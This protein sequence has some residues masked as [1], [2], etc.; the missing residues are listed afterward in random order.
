MSS[1][2]KEAIQEAFATAESELQI[3]E[4]L[5]I[6]HPTTTIATRKLQICYCID[7][8]GSMGPQ[9]D[10]VKEAASFSATDLAAQ[11]GIIEFALISFKD[12][13]E[14]VL[15]TGANFVDLQ[16]LTNAIDAL[17][18]DGGGDTPE[19]G[20][21][22]VV[23]AA[24]TLPWT[25]E[26]GS[27]RAIFLSTDEPSHERDATKDQAINSLL[28]NQIIFAGDVSNNY[29]DIADQTEGEI[30]TWSTAQE[31]SDALVAL[32]F[33]SI[34]F[35]TQDPIF[36]AN[37]L[38]NITA[39]LETG[40]VKE[41]ESYGF[42]IELPDKTEEG[43]QDLNIAIDN[44]DLLVSDFLQKALKIPNH[45]I[46][47]IYRPYLKTDLTQPQLDP[48]LVLFGSDFQVDNFEVTGNATFADILNKKFL[49]QKFTKK[50]FPG[51]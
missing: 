23:L 13:D 10:A 29:Q 40:E 51:L 30:I 41:F 8:T 18:A 25:F 15:Q 44:T 50:R 27:R 1:T 6:Q 14:T 45:P 36:L 49:S 17:V 7:H 33:N 34:T 11:F 46:K 20:Y 5:E 22:A 31:L 39:T 37:T 24:D 3:V 32:L 42:R 21:G 38:E 9:I 43:I 16:T 26:N 48:P 4:T 2:Y 19:N 35:D 47:F 12:E 28:E